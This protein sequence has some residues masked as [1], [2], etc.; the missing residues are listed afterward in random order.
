MTN[1]TSTLPASTA[2]E[3]RPV[4]WWATLGACFLTLQIWVLGSWVS[5]SR[6]VASDPGADTLS[7]FAMIMQWL[8]CLSFGLGGVW[9]VF[10]LG[11]S[12]LRGERFSGFQVLM[13][14][15]WTATWQDPTLNL[16]RP[17]FVYNSHYWNRGSWS[18][19]VPFWLSP[20]GSKMPEPIFWQ[21]GCYIIMQPQ[22]V[23]FTMGVIYALR[24]RCPQ[25]GFASTL[26]IAF[27]ACGALN[28][29]N[30]LVL[31]FGEVF[32]YPGV[33]HDW[34]LFPGTQYQY[35]VYEGFLW[36]IGTTACAALFCFPDANGHTLV[37][38]SIGKLQLST[39]K[40]NLLRVLAA[41][42][43]INIALSFY[44]FCCLL[45]STHIDT[46]PELPSYFSSGI[47]GE[48]TGYPCPTKGAP[49]PTVQMAPDSSLISHP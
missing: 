35:P 44:I 33:V 5:S 21:M 20:N 11:R 1:V 22:L 45:I 26:L 30:E 16:I 27:I 15:T 34:S 13:L 37:E 47:C 38:R 2:I 48:G 17:I 12:L 19:F 7:T 3:A 40:E 36:A 24:R 8:I 32:A 41:G 39:R 9:A 46:W 10:N 4:L 31:V 25:L 49:I 6:F 29:L 42:G 18:E 43:F 23:L 14:G 28:T